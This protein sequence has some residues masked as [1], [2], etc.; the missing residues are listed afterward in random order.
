MEKTFDTKTIMVITFSAF[1]MISA[2][3][4]AITVQDI[5][6]L[7]PT[8]FNWIAEDDE[9]SRRIFIE[10]IYDFAVK[11]QAREI[12]E[13]KRDEALIIPKDIDYFSKNLSLS[14]EEREKL[15]LLQPQT[16]A[17]ASRIQGI[18]PATIVRL[19]RHVKQSNDKEV[20]Q[21]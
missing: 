12:E 21:N 19:L 11:E 10:S 18:T 16:L 1:E 14:Y 2:T 17:A 4:D 7:E 13:V 9:L 20:L 5:A 6:K 8:I 3:S 15:V